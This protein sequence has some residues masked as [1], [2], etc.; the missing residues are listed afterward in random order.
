MPDVELGIGNAVFVQTYRIAGLIPGTLGFVLAGQH[1][2]WNGVFAVVAAFMLVG[3]G[4][5]LY[6][7][8]AVAHPVPPKSLREAIVEPFR[9]F[10]TRRGCAARA[11]H[12]LLQARRQHGDRAVDALV[13]IGPVPT[14][15]GLTENAACGL[16]HGG[17]SAVLMV[18]SVSI[19]RCGLWRHSVGNN[20]ALRYSRR[21]QQPVGT[22]D[23]DSPNI[24]A[25]DS[26]PLH[27]LRLARDDPVFRHAVRAV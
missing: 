25:S 26:A 7:G 13:H 22:S 8:E 14:Q 27:S 6:I 16:D 4:L 1:M 17:C 20:S 15:I 5:T 21:R 19:D 11:C 12:V 23:C 24:S 2:P 9:E 10:I 3:I 18:R